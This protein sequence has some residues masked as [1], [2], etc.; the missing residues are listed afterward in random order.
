MDSNA[1]TFWIFI[2][3][4]VFVVGILDN[5]SIVGALGVPRFTTD[6]NQVGTPGR[7]STENQVS[8]GR[9]RNGNLVY[10]KQRG[11]ME[12]NYVANP[13]TAAEFLSLK[14]NI[15]INERHVVKNW[16]VYS[17]ISRKQLAVGGLTDIDFQKKELRIWNT[18]G[19]PLWGTTSDTLLLLD[20]SG[21]VVDEYRYPVR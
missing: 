12:I 11:A 21:R 4:A 6:T 8:F 19:M 1:T 5:G 16:V 20:G 7:D 17:E 10:S 14:L 15:E 9:D 13:G 18:P 2:I 3:I